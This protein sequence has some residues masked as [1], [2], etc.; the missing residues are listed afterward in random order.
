ML[1]D[2]TSYRATLLLVPLLGLHYLVIPFRP[3]PGHPW[4]RAYGVMSAITASFQVSTCE[5]HAVMLTR[6]RGS[7]LRA[8]SLTSVQVVAYSILAVM[9]SKRASAKVSAAGKEIDICINFRGVIYFIG[10]V[11]R[12]VIGGSVGSYCYTLGA[13]WWTNFKSY[14][15]WLG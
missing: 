5:S 1:L 13:C 10:Q 4:E 11:W 2:S 6:W 12:V 7:E 15:L 9:A 8:Q 3:E 14:Y